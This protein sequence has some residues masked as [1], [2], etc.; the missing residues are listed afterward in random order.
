MTPP[1]IYVFERYIFYKNGTYSSI[2][3]L[4]FPATA[5]GACPRPTKGLI[6]IPRESII[7]I[8]QEV[9]HGQRI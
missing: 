7:Y 9:S 5:A 2:L 6:F 4:G 1:G 3:Q 8:N